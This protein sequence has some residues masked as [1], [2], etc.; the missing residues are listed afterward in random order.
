M[1]RFALF[2]AG[3]I[4]QVHGANIAAN[5]RTKL[6][7]VTKDGKITAPADAG[8]ISASLES[9]K[10]TVIQAGGAKQVLTRLQRS[11]PTLEAKPPGNAIILSADQWENARVEKGFLTANGSTT[12]SRFGSYTLQL[13]FRTP[14]KPHARGQKRGNSGVYH[15]GR[16]ETQIL[17]S[18]G[19]CRANGAGAR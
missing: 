4:G 14:Y 1:I 16:W 13:E 8:M 15:S 17:D 11:S 10:L 7:A 19:H 12:H 9:G 2:G 3:F 5:P 18:F 6:H